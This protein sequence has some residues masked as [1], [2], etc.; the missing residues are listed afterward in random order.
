MAKDHE[1]DAERFLN[2][3][4]ERVREL[5][6]IADITNR[7]ADEVNFEDYGRFRDMMS[8]CLSFLIIIDQRITLLDLTKQAKLREQFDELTVALW[9]VLL[10]G[11]LRFLEIIAKREYLPLGTRHVFV[12]ELRTLHEADKVLKKQEYQHRL[13]DVVRRRRQTAERILIEIIE[14]ALRLLLLED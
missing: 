9:S 2:V 13:S 10:D 11:S 6:A 5:L 12:R 14:R 3:L 1:G 7:S 8:E 4:E